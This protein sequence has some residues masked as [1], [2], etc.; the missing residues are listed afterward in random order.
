MARMK[1][2]LKRPVYGGSVD[3]T[4][5]SGF[6]PK[7]SLRVKKSMT[8]AFVFGLEVRDAEMGIVGHCA[9]VAM[10]ARSLGAIMDISESDAYILDTAAQLHE[11]GMFAIPPDLLKR[12]SPLT[13][14]ELERIRSQAQI[15]AEIAGMMHHPRV[16]SLIE[17]Q[18]DDH[19]ELEGVLPPED[20]LL[21]GILRVAD[22][23]AATTWPRPYQAA[24]PR[25]SR[26]QLLRLGAGSRFHPLAARLALEVPIVA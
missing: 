21:A 12:S 10:L 26:A 11:V 16:R 3:G 14:E 6:A 18:Y 7:E 1:D 4:V 17:H 13:L 2:L 15:S 20:L 19:A 22:V 24:L 9:A 5:E 25:E 23:L 8:S